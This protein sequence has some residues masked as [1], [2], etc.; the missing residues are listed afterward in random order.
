MEYSNIDHITLEE[1]GFISFGPTVSVLG[2]NEKHCK[3]WEG[4]FAKVHFSIGHPTDH[5][6][7]NFHITRNF[8]DLNNK[9]KI[10]VFKI[11]KSD[12][13][14]ITTL[15]V[16]HLLNEFLRPIRVI[17]NRPPDKKARERS[18]RFLSFDEFKKENKFQDGL[19]QAFES[20]VAI[21]RK[22]RLR[23]NS[24]VT[25]VLGK[26]AKSRENQS[27]IGNLLLP[28][29]TA[30]KKAD[31]GFLLSPKYAGAVIRVGHDFYKLN[32][33]V[34]LQCLCDKIFGEGLSRHLLFKTLLAIGRVSA[35]ENYEQTKK[36]HDPI[37]LTLE[38][39]NI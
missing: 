29:Q 33:D 16:S 32:N 2:L 19:K 10:V 21:K 25:K 22:R 4:R 5:N 27:L 39:S 23:I 15:I 30:K 38:Q 1:H 28:L 6:E 24:R 37:V 3:I 31:A 9:P 26:F 20:S 35:S 8:K 7:I 17:Y 11:N 13:E 14:G 12:L 18:I 34:S 36:F